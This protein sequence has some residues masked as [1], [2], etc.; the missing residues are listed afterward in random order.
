MSTA[1]GGGNI[2]T[3]GLV[4]Y[5]DAANTKSFVSGN[6]IW[7]DLSRGGN[8]G[9]LTNGPTFNSGNGGS[10]VFDGVDD[11]IQTANINLT[12]TNAVSV[13]FW[14]KLNSYTEVIGAGKV[15]LEFSTNF[16]SSLVGFLV[17]IADDSNALYGNTFPITLN[18]RGNIGFNVTY[19]PKTLVNDLAWHHWV[20]IFD[21]GLTGSEGV[22]Y[23]DGILRSGTL[24]SLN[25][26]NTNN[27]G[28]LPLFLSGRAAVANSNQQT[29]NIK[30]YNRVLSTTEVLQNYNATKSRFGL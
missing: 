9:T 12:N 23:I 6:T 13:D 28:N 20:C 15:L 5:L 1:E 17:A 19:F 21:K 8:N 14:C 4:L 24:T 30:L 2:I 25:N 26:N 10:I 7:N 16:N 11:Y 29:G 18:L 3:D 22:L 27:F